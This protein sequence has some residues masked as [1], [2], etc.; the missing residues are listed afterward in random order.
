M[1]GVMLEPSL[2]VIVPTKDRPDLLRRALESIA[3]QQFAGTIQTVVVD[4]G[5]ALPQRWVSE[6]DM[7]ITFVRH[8]SSR[9]LAGAR[10]T[11]LRHA[12]GTYVG[13]L[14]DDD[15]WLPHHAAQLVAALESSSARAAYS[16]AERWSQELQHGQWV[17]TDT[18]IE[19]RHA[20]FDLDMV[21]LTNLTPVNTVIHERSLIDETGGFDETLSV[22]EDWDLW[23]RMRAITEFAHVPN[24]TCAYTTRGST[25]MTQQR[26]REFWPAQARIFHRYRSLAEGF[27][28]LGD[29]QQSHLAR[30]LAS[31]GSDDAAVARER[32]RIALDQP[33]SDESLQSDF[34]EGFGDTREPAA[35]TAVPSMAIGRSGEQPLVSILIPTYNRAELLREAL[36]SASNQTYANL[37]ILVSDN[38][39]TDATAALL[40]EATAADPRI[41]GWVNDANVGSQENYRV[42]LREARGEFVK[43]LD[44]DDLLRHDCVERLLEPLLRDERLVLATSKRRLI[45]QQGQQLADTTYSQS[46]A[47]SARRIAGAE[48][49]NLCLRTQANW[50]GEP[51]TPLFRRDVVAASTMFQ[52]GG[53]SFDASADLALWFSL[54]SRGDG[55]YDP[56]ELSSLRLHGAQDCQKPA[57]MIESLTD[58]L[59]LIELAPMYGFMVDD[60]DRHVG[61]T[62]LLARV[63]A[64]YGALHQ[65]PAAAHL[66]PAMARI[67]ELLA[68]TR[69]DAVD[70]D[71]PFY[72]TSVVV[73]LTDNL[74]GAI[75]TIEALAES[76]P[77]TWFEVLF[78]DDA[79]DDELTQLLDSLEGDIQVVRH[80]TRR[81]AG[82]SYATGIE[83]A[84]GEHVVLLHPRA[85]VQ[86]GWLPPL[87]GL[88]DASPDV[89]AVTPLVC[90]A[91]AP[92]VRPLA[93]GERPLAIAAS[94]DTLEATLRQRGPSA[95]DADDALAATIAALTALTARIVVEP[96][97]RC[98]PLADEPLAP[99]H[100]DLDSVAAAS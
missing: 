16:V 59:A 73:P 11:G 69:V 4:D 94:R 8:T 49:V 7:N 70:P 5:S 31:M 60:H 37:E 1:H 72:T 27:T 48:L 84:R 24:V 83:H 42:L 30:V 10:N 50:I 67:P 98:A 2:T 56:D 64:T 20:R 54:L 76:T 68:P 88:L 45:D 78:V 3:Q 75:S 63:A 22:V 12:R 33:S 15:V 79:A 21:L 39:S 38:R 74:S 51:T 25:N 62:S 96:A 36:E 13:Y 26:I 32:A 81:G 100:R 29:V 41:R 34:A 86:P 53:R 44:D 28:G 55:W 19:H 9:D 14:D 97:S 66:L 17:T 85:I 18:A 43:F 92:D 93:P 65:D 99:S 71:V 90:G 52:F 82:A 47:P 95:T 6:L 57:V 80:D 89:D 46:L 58:F 87:V 61:L 40:T 91:D 23:I 35:C 77:G